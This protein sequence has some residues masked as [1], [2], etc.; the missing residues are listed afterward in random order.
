MSS[1]IGKNITLSVFGESHGPAIGAVING[2]PAGEDINMEKIL[3]QMSR[4]APGKD[5]TSTPRKESDIPE[6]LSGVKNGKTTGAPL[7]AVIKN[8]N[9][10]SSDYSNLVDTPRPSHADYPALVKY[11][12]FSD[13]NGSG[14]FS[15]RLTAPVV[16]AGS[17]CRQLLERRGISVG[18]HILRIGNIS[19]I[20]FDS[21]NVDSR[22]L[23]A[24]SHKSFA[25]INDI[26]SDMRNEIE[27]ARMDSDSVGGIIEVAASGLPVGIGEPMFDT[28]EGVLAK[29]LFGIPAVKG[30]EFGAGF[31]LGS[32]RGSQA[33]DPYT[34]DN[35]K[36]SNTSNN[37]GGIIG[38][39]S[40]GMP[41]I[42]RVAVK[43][44]P[45]I[46]K[47][48]QTVSIK[49]KKVSSL[50]IEGRHDP[51]IV[52][53]AL[54]VIESAICIGLCDLMKEGGLL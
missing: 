27:S 42:I 45:S 30:V 49:D 26:E 16:F 21:V 36:I 47:E 5:K 53:R 29:I 33:N 12:G 17:V 19:D 6:I 52:P 35:G 46:H 54:P 15:G 3:F 13:L 39:I 9:T 4:R 31:S 20:P 32:M 40:N 48:Q 11:G 10:R 1:E 2:L 34:V 24:L 25:V 18:G 41:L 22:Q 51:C 28:V 23:D 50:V 37:N 7:A 44:T 14:H 8:T 38:G 43:P